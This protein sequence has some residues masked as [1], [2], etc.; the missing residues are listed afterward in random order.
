[1]FHAKLKLFD[2]LKHK[3]IVKMQEDESYF[4]IKGM[5]FYGI[6]M[7]LYRTSRIFKIEYIRHKE[8][9]KRNV[10]ISEIEISYESSISGVARPFYMKVYIRD[11]ENIEL[12]E[13]KE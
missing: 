5:D 3:L 9:I 2:D 1:M 11:I 6:F 8:I 13:F 4:I 10:A 12:I 7:E